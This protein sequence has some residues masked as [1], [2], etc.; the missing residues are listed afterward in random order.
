MSAGGVRGRNERYRT[1]WRYVLLIA[2]ALV[3]VFPV[4][5]MVVSSLKPD[6]Q[7]LRDTG[8]VRAFLPVGDISLDNYVSA[9]ERAPIGRFVYNSVLVTG[10]TVVFGLFLNSLAGF[11]FAKLR[12][13][14]ERSSCPS[15]SPRSSC[16]SRRSRSRCSCWSTRC[17]GSAPTV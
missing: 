1:V 2:V 7:L 10:L 16:R 9:F 8:S 13:R 5:F 15:S 6:L 3:F 12:W 17:R 11:A 14:G 4:V